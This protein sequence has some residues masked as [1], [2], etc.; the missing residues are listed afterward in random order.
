MTYEEAQNWWDKPKG[1]V[2]E[3]LYGTIRD[4]DQKY[5]VR[6]EKNLAHLRMYG[7]SVDMGINQDLFTLLDQTRNIRVNII[8]RVAETL[9]SKITKNKPK[10]RFL[11][12]GGNEIKKRSA[13]KLEKFV[14]GVAYKDNHYDQSTFDFLNACIFGTCAR[15]FFIDS[16]GNPKSESVIIENIKIDETANAITGAKLP[17][18]LIEVQY[19]D[20]DTIKKKFNIKKDIMLKKGFSTHPFF[21][22]ENTENLYMVAEAWKPKTSYSKGRHVICCEGIDLL[23]EPYD[24]ADY[25]FEFF[26]FTKN[27]LGFFGTG[28]C[29]RLL[30]IQHYIDKLL[31]EIHEAIHL[32]V[33]KIFA[34]VDTVDPNKLENTI[35]GLVEYAGINPPL[36]SQLLRLPPEWAD[37]LK[38]LIDSA[39]QEIGL[40][41]LS[42]TSQKPLGLD[43]GKALREFT[44]IESDRFNALSEAWQKYHMN[45][46]ERY[47]KVAQ[48]S[49]EN[50]P[51]LQFKALDKD[52]YEII[53]WADIGD[54]DEI[55]YC[56]RP[57][58]VNL[59]S[60]TPTGKLA[61]VVEMI[62]SGI[63]GQEDALEMLDYPD[64]RE[65][66]ERVTS[67]SKY[68]KFIFDKMLEKGLYSPPDQ[69][70]DLQK[71]IKI[72]MEYINKYRLSDVPPENLPLIEQWVS[73]AMGIMEF[74]QEQQEKE[75][76][77]AMA[78]EQELN[79]LSALDKSSQGNIPKN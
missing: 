33:P 15:K 61:D 69:F 68:I 54:L 45:C 14:S 17:P 48:R 30:V 32:G 59:L 75:A 20:K 51:E 19:M 44:D 5:T 70:A 36:V 16:D 47:L 64:I 78:A 2:H 60:S 77:D 3:C 1:A 41:E 65:Y 40:S 29:E 34:Q 73:D 46:F 11:T 62:S 72:G 56:L 79:E 4:L 26:K 18:Y 71:G 57:Y 9:Q 49:A 38:F 25:P 52:G 10:A 50:N 39:Y 58:P 8:R 53:D 37:Q 63:I 12:E 21:S 43:S 24:E 28:V 42:T 22:P 31:G 13:I 55:D 76:E 23:D 7:Q 67:Q 35:G 27:V 66:V 6:S 74:A